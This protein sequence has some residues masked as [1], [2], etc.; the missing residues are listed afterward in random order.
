MSNK[1]IL[2]L[3]PFRAESPQHP[4]DTPFG[5]AAIEASK[6]GVEVLFASEPG[7]LLAVRKDEWTVSNGD[8]SAVYDRFPSRS[9]P[10]AW[11]KL[12]RH[13][14]H[15][16]WGNSPVLTNL[17]ADKVE[18]QRV[19][20]DMP[21]LATDYNCFSEKLKEWGSAFIKPRYGAL[22][23]GVKRVSPGDT[24][25]KMT[26]GAVRGV[27]E[28]T[29]L[30]REIRPPVDFSA[31]SLRVLVQA[32][33]NGWVVEQ[34]VARVSDSSSVANVALGAQ[35]IAGEDVIPPKSLEKAIKISISA[36]DKLKAYRGVGLVLELGV[37]VLFDERWEPWVIE[38]NGRPAGRLGALAKLQPTRF[39]S[40][41]DRLCLTPILFLAAKHC[42]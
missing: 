40:V 3:L 25:P 41:R 32:S 26:D 34:T 2:I 36:C 6:K 4:S 15:L 22:G 23:R 10:E 13:W 11:D 37:D 29:I 18:T 17:C 20:G 19:I 35:A 16:P 12:W 39:G 9:Q 27:L 1:S 24:L 30:Q 38:V 33:N 14:G 31:L 5:R 8:P 7:K 28:P 21:E 42:T